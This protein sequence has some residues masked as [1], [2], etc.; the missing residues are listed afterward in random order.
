MLRAEFFARGFRL[1]RPDRS[2]ITVADTLEIAL[3]NPHGQYISASFSPKGIDSGMPDR[4]EIRQ[5]PRITATC[6]FPTQGVFSVLL[7]A[8]TEQFG[9][10]QHIGTFEAVRR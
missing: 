9:T 3:D 5:G 8:N 7:F 4:C 2:Q 6:S 10:F 1:E